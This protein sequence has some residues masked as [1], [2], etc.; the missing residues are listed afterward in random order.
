MDRHTLEACAEDFNFRICKLERSTGLHFKRIVIGDDYL[1]KPLVFNSNLDNY[2]LLEAEE[3]WNPYL[4]SYEE[5]RD[6]GMTWVNLA[7]LDELRS[8]RFEEELHSI[9]TTAENFSLAR[10]ALLDSLQKLW[11]RSPASKL[12]IAIHFGLYYAVITIPLALIAFYKIILRDAIAHYSIRCFYQNGCV[13]AEVYYYKN[14]STHFDDFCFLLE[15]KVN[16]RKKY[17]LDKLEQEAFQGQ[18]QQAWRW[19]QEF[20]SLKGASS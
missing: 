9:M 1:F 7:G 13:V 8:Y 14:C 6:D 3:D 16:E 12:D 11:E 20:F 18:C 4:L 5:L 19:E 17:E 15:C 10:E 2:E